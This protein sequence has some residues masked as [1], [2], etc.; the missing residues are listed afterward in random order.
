[1]GGWVL[2]PKCLAGGQ[3]RIYDFEKVGGRKMC[4]GGGFF[5]GRADEGRMLRGC[6]ISRAATAHGRRL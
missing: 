3:W 6:T 4:L 5:R 1:M 2:T